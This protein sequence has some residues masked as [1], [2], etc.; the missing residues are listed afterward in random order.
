MVKILI[1]QK[2][3]KLQSKTYRYFCKK[4]KL[5]LKNEENG[6]K[7]KREREREREKETDREGASGQEQ[8]PRKERKKRNET[9]P[10]CTACTQK[11]EN[12]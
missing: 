4:R 10:T 2:I 11:I 8:V 12:K 7:K 9:F 6:K 5:S 1:L 3:Q